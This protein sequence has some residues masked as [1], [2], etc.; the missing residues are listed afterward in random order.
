ME[1]SPSPA[2]VDTLPFGKYSSGKQVIAPETNADE[3]PGK[4]SLSLKGNGVI[5]AHFHS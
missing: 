4:S 1:P 5:P 2:L 3:V